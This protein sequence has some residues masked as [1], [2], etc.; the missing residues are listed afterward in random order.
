MTA[1]NQDFTLSA[2]SPA[3]LQPVMV[4]GPTALLGSVFVISWDRD[5]QPWESW[6]YP[7]RV[8]VGTEEQAKAHA[9]KLQ[10]DRGGSFSVQEVMG[11]GAPIICMPNDKITQ[12]GFVAPLAERNSD[13]A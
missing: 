7:F 1:N 13:R 2:E 12:P 11:E 9:G 10:E 8:I 4:V 5:P 3:D 6:S